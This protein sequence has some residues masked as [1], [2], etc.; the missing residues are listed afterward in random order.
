MCSW[1]HP[2]VVTGFSILLLYPLYRALHQKALWL[3]FLV[4]LVRTVFDLWDGELARQCDQ[5]SVF[6]GYLDETNDI[7]GIALMYAFAY[8]QL[9]KSR[10]PIPI[11]ICIACVALKF[12][13]SFFME[14]T[15]HRT[16]NDLSQTVHDNY[17]L[18]NLLVFCVYSLVT[19]HSR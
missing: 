17:L 11:L 13:S 14:G 18:S 9:T 10:V 6:G 19:Y 15:E 7:C 8:T 16:T 1:L 5:K 3:V 4:V 2:N 12:I